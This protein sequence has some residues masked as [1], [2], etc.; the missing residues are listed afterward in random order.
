MRTRP[1][2]T[3]VIRGRGR[4]LSARSADP[5]SCEYRL[6]APMVSLQSSNSISYKPASRTLA[7]QS[8]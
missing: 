1:I 2:H 7:L 6:F 5:F 8:Q 4:L 3:L